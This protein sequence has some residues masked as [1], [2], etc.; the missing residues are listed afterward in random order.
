MIFIPLLMTQLLENK[1][2][3]FI[4]DIS[5]QLAA[6][7]V[8]VPP[9]LQSDTYLLSNTSYLTKASRITAL[10]LQRQLRKRKNAKLL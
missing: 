4:E 5:L 8:E 10:S 3:K 9:C 1:P 7:I 2:W 6:K